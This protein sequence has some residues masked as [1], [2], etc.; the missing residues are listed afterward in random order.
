VTDTLWMINPDAYLRLVRDA[1]WPVDRFQS[2]LA[3][4]MERL[5]LD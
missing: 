2:W 5:F 3:D 4:L 1:E